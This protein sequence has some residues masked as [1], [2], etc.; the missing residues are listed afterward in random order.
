MSSRA[1]APPGTLEAFVDLPLGDGGAL[2]EIPLLKVSP[3][4]P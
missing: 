1:L 2:M 4:Y 3:G